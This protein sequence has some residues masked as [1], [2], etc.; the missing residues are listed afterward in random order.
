MEWLNKEVIHG[1][2]YEFYKHDMHGLPAF[3]HHIFCSIGFGHCINTP[4]LTA[5]SMPRD[6]RFAW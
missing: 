6:S 3:E 5:T 2:A 1:K 4:F